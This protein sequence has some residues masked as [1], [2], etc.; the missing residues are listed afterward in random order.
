[1]KAVLAAILLSLPGVSLAGGLQLLVTHDAACGDYARW[2]R[3]VAPAYSSM[4]QGQR[5][6][7]LG[8]AADGPWPDGLVIGPRPRQT[9]SFLLL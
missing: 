4:P 8:L 1:M 9:P 6:P 5:A 7:L 3:D 2:Q